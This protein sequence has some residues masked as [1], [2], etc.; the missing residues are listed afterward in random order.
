LEKPLT[1][2]ALFVPKLSIGGQFMARYV[3]KWDAIQRMEFEELPLAVAHVQ[4]LPNGTVAE[5]NDIEAKAG[6]PALYIVTAGNPAVLK[7]E[8]PDN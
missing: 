7:I 8:G 6:Q 5:I 2:F 1:R 4:T 3:V